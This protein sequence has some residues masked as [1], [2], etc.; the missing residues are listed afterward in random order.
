M[1]AQ[2]VS[3]RFANLL[4]TLQHETSE[5]GFEKAI[6]EEMMLTRDWAAARDRAWRAA[7]DRLIDMGFGEEGAVEKLTEKLG[8]VERNDDPSP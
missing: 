3:K 4:T 8:R 5:K 2:E 7:N 1:I 6:R